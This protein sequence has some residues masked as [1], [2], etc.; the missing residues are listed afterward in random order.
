MIAYENDAPVQTVDFAYPDEDDAEPVTTRDRWSDGPLHEKCCQRFATVPRD[1]DVALPMLETRLSVLGDAARE[2]AEHGDFD[3]LARLC[4]KARATAQRIKEE[5]LRY[6]SPG[7]IERHGS[8]VIVDDA[9]RGKVVLQFPH[10]LTAQ[11]KRWVRIC[12]FT[13]CGDGATFWRARTFRRDENIALETARL[14]VGELGRMG[15]KEAA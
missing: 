9:E 3:T 13:G 15:W 1:P 11:I 4:A 14:C 5:Q 6:G 10:A 12:G 7:G 8:V 2:A